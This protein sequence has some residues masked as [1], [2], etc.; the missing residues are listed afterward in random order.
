[1]LEL[2]SSL[3]KSKQERS[4]IADYLQYI[5]I[6]IDDLALIGH[7]FS[8]EEVLIHTLNRLSDEFKELAVTLRARDSPISFEKLDDKQ[9][10][11]EAYLKRDDRLPGSPIIAHFNHKSKRKCR[12]YSKIAQKGVAKFPPDSMGTNQSFLPL[13]PLYFNHHQGGPF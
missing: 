12:K 3:M 1:M 7:T 11:D 5:K 2:L 8:D 10:N 6:I 9:T 4:T 13:H